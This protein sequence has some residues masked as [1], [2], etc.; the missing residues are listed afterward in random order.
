MIMIMTMGKQHLHWEM[1]FY[2]FIVYHIITGALCAFVDASQ[3]QLGGSGYKA[4]ALAGGTP[5]RL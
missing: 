2:L 5:I 3:K 1:T 4:L